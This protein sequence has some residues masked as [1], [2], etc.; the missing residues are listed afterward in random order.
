MM[1]QIIDNRGT[2][3]TSRLFLLAKE[4]NGIVVCHNPQVMRD[5]AYA[6]GIVGVDFIS[7][8]EYA[9]MFHFHLPQ[10][11]P[12]YIDELS[13]FLKYLDK[14]ICGYSESWEEIHK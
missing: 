5:K 1:K 10:D 13:C 3:K 2:G 11:K 14:N 9:H 8:S 12:I 7:Y 4:N 6:Y